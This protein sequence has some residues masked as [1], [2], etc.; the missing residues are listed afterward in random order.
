MLGECRFLN[1]FQNFFAFFLFPYFIGKIDLSFSS[2]A[3][4]DT[5]P[6]N[7]VSS[8]L[9]TPQ[10]SPLSVSGAEKEDGEV[11]EEDREVEKEDD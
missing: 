9:P 5:V 3:P 4:K 10:L 11:E 2:A 8:P 6:T 1:H 7:W